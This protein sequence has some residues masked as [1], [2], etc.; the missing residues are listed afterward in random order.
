MG[1]DWPGDLNQP[2]LNHSRCCQHSDALTGTIRDM[3]LCTALFITAFFTVGALAMNLDPVGLIYAPAS[4]DKRQTFSGTLGGAAPLVTH[5]GDSQRPYG[6]NGDTFPDYESAAGR[7]CN[8]QF[9][10]CQKIANTDKSA[11]FSLQNCQDQLTSC[12]STVSSTSVA[13]QGGA[14]ISAPTASTSTSDANETVTA[15]MA[16]TTIPYDSEF[17]LICD[18]PEGGV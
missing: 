3:A 8:N 13:P 16:Q 12:M 6:V 9:D 15:H 18:I 17:D 14:T 5:T 4:L 7:S 11:S 10:S 1:K 2:N